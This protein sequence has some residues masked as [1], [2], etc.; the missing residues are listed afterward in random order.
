MPYKGCKSL[1]D[2]MQALADTAAA[3][4]RLWLITRGSQPVIETDTTGGFTQAAVWGLG[5]AIGLEHP[6]LKPVRIDLDERCSGSAQASAIAAEL[7]AAHEPVEDQI[8]FRNGSGYVPRVRRYKRHVSANPG[9]AIRADAT[10][11]ITGGLGGLGLLVAKWLASRGARHILAM[12]RSGAPPGVQS[13]LAALEA[14][15]ATVRVARGDVT[16]P[17]QVAAV[18]AQVDPRYPLAGIVHAAT[19]ANSAALLHSQSWDAFRR[20]M[21]AKIDGALNLDHLTQNMPIDFFVCF[22]SLTAVFGDS[23]LGAYTA[24][25]AFLDA[26]ASQRRA[27]G[28][29]CVTIDWGIWSEAG[30]LA[31]ADHSRLQLVKQGH[32]TIPSAA[33][34]AAFGRVLEQDCTRICVVPIDWA[35]FSGGPGAGEPLFSELVTPRA[36]AD[37]PRNAVEEQTD[38]TLPQIDIRRRLT[39]A[40]NGD[41]PAML[42][43]HF[44]GLAA[45]VLD[46][47]PNT[48]LDAGE[49]LVALGLDSLMAIDL[50]NSIR[51]AVGVNVPLNEF[52]GGT[53]IRDVVSLAL[54]SMEEPPDRG[55]R[56][57]PVTSGAESEWITGTI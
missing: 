28:R 42:T 5:K 39:Q 15:G 17:M 29:T 40:L 13:E 2:L 52:L 47:P 33:G 20:A 53:S 7:F 35:K 10:Y 43:A 19:A 9:G 32:G 44:S 12:G 11:L 50:K 23:G 4:P 30:T 16:D 45:R 6:E 14:H 22:S 48:P 34:M 46:L 55:A 25:N 51:N 37:C 1:L 36:T 24:A 26:F 41:R 54:S 31:G 57:V 27:N 8:A 56:C 3:P 21:S 49:S 38:V 18:L